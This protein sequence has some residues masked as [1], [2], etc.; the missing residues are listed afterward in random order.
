MARQRWGAS[1]VSPC[2]VALVGFCGMASAA[3]STDS[4]CD[5]IALTYWGDDTNK[6][7]VGLF[8]VYG[9]VMAY[10]FGGV[11]VA[12]DAFM[13][14]I[15]AITAE[16]TL[17]RVGSGS[18]ERDVEVGVWNKTVS[19]LSLMALGSSAPEIM[20][21]IIEVVGND[22]EAGDL[23]PGT[24]VGSAAFNMLMIIAICVSIVPVKR[25]EAIIVLYITAIASV[26]AYFWLYLIVDVISPQKI[27]IWEACVTCGFFPLLLLVAWMADKGWLDGDFCHHKVK[28]MVGSNTVRKDKAAMKHLVSVGHVPVHAQGTSEWNT[29]LRRAIRRIQ[30]R[31]PDLTIEQ[32]YVKA[33]EHCKSH[34]HAPMLVGELAQDRLETALNGS[35]TIEV[36]PAGTSVVDRQT[37]R[38]DTS[39]TSRLLST[40]SATDV[41]ADPLVPGPVTII[42]VSRTSSATSSLGGISLHRVGFPQALYKCIEQDGKIFVPVKRR[43]NIRLPLEVRVGYRDSTAV[44]GRDYTM[45][46]TTRRVEFAPGESVKSVEVGIVRHDDYHPNHHFFLELSVGV[47]M[48]P[49]DVRWTN[50][51]TKIRIIDSTKRRGCLECVRGLFTT[52]TSAEPA[53][54]PYLEQ[55]RVALR[56]GDGDDD[57]DDEEE[58]GGVAN[59]VIPNP[60]FTGLSG[61]GGGAINGSHDNDTNGNGNSDDDNA[62]DD[63]GC[64]CFGWF[65]YFYLLVPSVLLAVFSIPVTRWHGWGAFVT[66]LLW[67]GVWTLLAGDLATGMGC[68][69][70][71]EDTVTAVTF[72]ALGT[73]V[74]DTFASKIAAENDETADPAIGNVTGSNAV[75]VFLGVGLSWLVGAIYQESNGRHFTVKSGALAFSVVLFTIFAIVWFV[76]LTLRRYLVGGELGGTGIVKWATIALFCA[77]WFVFILLVAFVAYGTIENPI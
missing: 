72:V 71:L 2:V 18:A 73:S 65:V 47:G 45:E 19:N 4:P 40:D 55:I 43:G 76:V 9:L 25:V 41:L 7:N 66:S 6:S 61:S 13:G 27:E 64:S 17:V 49:T 51:C 20:L 75:N 37:R 28:K 44:F 33:F 60:S 5:G 67:I 50:K 59:D 53:D 10:I 22:F 42:P 48:D 32:V 46:D 15:E 69:I 24:I 30:R 29:A 77:M 12:A 8:I 68:T 1:S 34:D 62:D 52:L 35:T 57:D 38:Q 63:G 70:G 23:G 58:E 11:A 36:T 54:S 56:G 14:S 31:E 74:P 3:N 21:A 16:T 39:S 26:F